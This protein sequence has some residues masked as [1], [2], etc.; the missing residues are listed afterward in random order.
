MGTKNEPTT[1]RKC[2][3]C[4]EYASGKRGLCQKHYSQLRRVLDEIPVENRAIAIEKLIREG[5]LL[6]AR[7][8]KKD[9]NPNEF[10]SLLEE[11]IPPPI[12]KSWAKRPLDALDQ[13]V[14]RMEES[15][16]IVRAAKRRAEAKKQGDQQRRRKSQ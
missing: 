1:N 7:Q 14:E 8:G 13:E 2:L 15:D 6:P 11:F 3:I 12:E 4:G 16:P 5:K 9:E 10:E